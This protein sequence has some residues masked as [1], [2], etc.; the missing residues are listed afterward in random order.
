MMKRLLLAVLLSTGAACKQKAPE[1]ARVPVKA[2]VAGVELIDY[3]QPAGA[4]ETLGPAS[5][6]VRETDDLGPAVMFLGPG[7][8]KYP[9]SVHIGISRYPNPVDKSSDPKSYYDYSALIPSH[10]L[11]AAYAKRSFNGRMLDTYAFEMP[12]RRLHERKVLYQKRV[13]TAIIPFPGGFYAIDHS[14]PAEIHK[15][16]LP[17]FAAIVASFKPVT[18]AA[19]KTP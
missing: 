2:T 10:K 17:V 8:A 13:D 9:R 4:F 14:A 6:Q 1:P 5:W 7:T 12:F 19:T 11:A 3:T 15:E 16:T 18:A